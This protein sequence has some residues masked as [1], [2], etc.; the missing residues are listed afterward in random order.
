MPIN[1]QIWL[2]FNNGNARDALI[3]NGDYFLRDHTWGC[4]D[5]VLVINQLF[6]WA[7]TTNSG[8][9]AAAAFTAALELLTSTE[10][11]N[12][13]FDLVHCYI[14]LSDDRHE[15]LPI[16][17]EHV[18]CSLADAARDHA[19]TLSKDAQQRDLILLVAA[20]LPR[21]ADMLG[22]HITATSY[23]NVA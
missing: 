18:A 3:G 1:Q 5:R 10:R 2:W 21:L 23:A 6:D 22:L 8:S 12:D 13:A 14:V 19:A 9:V 11:T 7:T 17:M 20:R 4:H 15:S 16:D